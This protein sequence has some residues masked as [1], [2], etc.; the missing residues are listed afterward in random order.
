MY[1]TVETLI[2]EG[3]RTDD[4]RPYFM[5]EYAHA[6]GNGPGNLKEYW[7]AIY[8]YDRLLGGCIWEWVDHGLRRHTAEGEEWFAYG[9][10]FGDYPNDGNF[11]IDGLNFPDRVPH[12]GLIEYKQVLAP[13]QVEP[14]DLRAGMLKI[15]NRLDFA[16]LAHLHGAWTLRRDG[17]L[18]QQGALPPLEVQA[19]GEMR[20]TLPYTLPAG[21]PGAEYWLDDHLHAGRRHALGAARLCRLAR[22][23]RRAGG[24]PGA[25][26]ARVVIAAVP[27]SGRSR[28]RVFAQYG[29]FPAALRPRLGA[30]RAWEYQ[31]FP[32]LT[33][34]PRLNV[35]RAPTDNDVHIAQQWRQHGLD[36]LQQ[37][38]E[39]VALGSV[40]PGAVEIH[41][42]SVLAAATL[43]PA[44][45]CRSRYVIY[46]SG[47]IRIDTTVTPRKELPNLPR[48]G[49]QLRLPGRFDRFTWY[50][51]GPHESYSDRK[52]SAP[53]GVYRRHGA[54]AVRAVH[55]SAGKRQQSRHPLGG[56]DGH[57]R[58]RAVGHRPTAAQRERPPL[59]PG[60]LHRRAPHHR[61]APPRRNHPPPRPPAS[62][63]GQQ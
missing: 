37:R 14:V 33:A 13:A 31:R 38:I 26:A 50:G 29:G 34:G 49:L 45:A 23:V 24:N 35:W 3:Q 11:C 6:M 58:L 8:R 55:L 20:V 25:A 18:L 40:R 19:G 27:A 54:A 4:P 39:L 17:E 63:P 62:P 43:T 7:E 1:P 10:D 2:A 47:D 12:S 56:G 36:R 57:T 41:V 48:L 21:T 44:F 30:I 16:S 15:T 28:R 52:E 46:G 42:E 9:G 22:A 5:C 53:V 60:G 61:P 32:L 51:R 59:H